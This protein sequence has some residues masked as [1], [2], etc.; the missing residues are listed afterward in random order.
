[1]MLIPFLEPTQE[2]GQ[3]KGKILLKKKVGLVKP[4]FEFF[5]TANRLFQSAFTGELA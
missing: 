4:D 3:L 2:K 5:Q 1:M